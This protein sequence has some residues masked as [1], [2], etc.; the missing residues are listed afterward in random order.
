M[1]EMVI[2]V[3]GMA[4]LHRVKNLVAVVVSSLIIGDATEVEEKMRMAGELLQVADPISGVGCKLQHS[5]VPVGQPLH[6]LL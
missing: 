3:I 1:R 6:Q 5:S 4:L 2:L